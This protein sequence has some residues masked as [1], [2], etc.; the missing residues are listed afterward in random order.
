MDV[1][2]GK[3]IR[4]YLPE[5]YGNTVYAPDDCCVMCNKHPASACNQCRSIWYCSKSCQTKDWP[6]H[7]I[8][9]KAFTNEEPRPSPNHKRALFFPVDETKPRLIWV[10]CER[11]KAEDGGEW[12]KLHI[13]DYLGDTSFGRAR[14]HYNPITNRRF[15]P[16]GSMRND[17]AIFLQCREAGLVDGSSPNQSITATTMKSGE[18]P[19][20]PWCGPVIAIRER[21]VDFYS[22]INLGDFRQT[23]DFLI[24]YYRGEKN[25]L[26]SNGKVLLRAP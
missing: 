12:E 21:G 11:K 6:T 16:P 5:Y 3:I 9:C 23:V 22:D 4:S 1:Y 26:V 18:P 2:S 25:L 14:M 24:T 10:L 15:T 19:G 13:K 17:H 20:T 7:K 8:L